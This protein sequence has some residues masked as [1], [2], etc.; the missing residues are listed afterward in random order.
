MSLM[1]G[2]KPLPRKDLTLMEKH[3]PDEKKRLK[4]LISQFPGRTCNPT[5][6]TPLRTITSPGFIEKPH[7]CYFLSFHLSGRIHEFLSQIC[8]W[9]AKLQR[10]SRHC[11]EE[12]NIQTTFKPRHHIVVVGLF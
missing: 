11:Q 5:L 1:K 6:F 3:P 9:V 8:F 10:V 2:S 4:S 7:S 12:Q